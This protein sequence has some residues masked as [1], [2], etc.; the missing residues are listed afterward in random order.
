MKNLKEY[1]INESEEEVLVITHD[2]DDDLICVR[3]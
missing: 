1:L 3:V 2:E